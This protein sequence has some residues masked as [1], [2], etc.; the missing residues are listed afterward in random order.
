LFRDDFDDL[1][2]DHP[3]SHGGNVV[4]LAM[5]RTCA[6]RLVSNQVWLNSGSCNSHFVKVLGDLVDD[7]VGHIFMHGFE[8]GGDS[9]SCPVNHVGGSIHAKLVPLRYATMSWFTKELVIC[10]E[11]EP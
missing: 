6:S 9:I 1:L 10:V 8:A 3:A 2:R 5:L 11:S 4:Q 7:F